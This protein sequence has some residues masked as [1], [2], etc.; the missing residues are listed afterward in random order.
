MKSVNI[1][2]ASA[3][4]SEYV[5]DLGSGPLVCTRDGQPVAALVLIDEDS[6]ESLLVASSPVFQ[7]IARESRDQLRDTGGVSLEEIERELGL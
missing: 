6:L 5:Q 7:R 2:D 4:L 1:A 3:P